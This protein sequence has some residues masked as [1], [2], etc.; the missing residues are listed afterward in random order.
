MK[1]KHAENLIER[2][3][4][5]SKTTKAVLDIGK[6]YSDFSDELEKEFPNE[7]EHLNSLKDK[8]P[9]DREDFLNPKGKSEVDISKYQLLGLT[10]ADE[11]LKAGIRANFI[12]STSHKRI[13]EI[14][15]LEEKELN[16]YDTEKLYEEAL[17]KGKADDAKI[18]KQREHKLII[19]LCFVIGGVVGIILSIIGI[20]SL[21]KKVET[22]V[23]WET[24]AIV[25]LVFLII[26]LNALVIVG[27]VF[28]SNRGKDN[29]LLSDYNE[30]V[31]EIHNSIINSY[32]VSY[33]EVLDNFSSYKEKFLEISKKALI[34]DNRIRGFEVA[35]IY[36]FLPEIDA[37]LRY[38]VLEMMLNVPNTPYDIAL[39]MV[40]RDVSREKQL[41]EDIAREERRYE[42]QK[43]LSKELVEYKE[44]EER[45]N[46]DLEYLARKEAEREYYEEKKKEN[47]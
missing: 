43:K 19:G 15:E 22:D 32:K 6:D 39:T 2:Y 31:E 42:A 13:K 28:L 25:G 9:K 12:S 37:D 4:K 18:K 26:A 14:K 8:L 30:R 40:N 7:V 20:A 46:R 23:Q 35:N 24:L 34:F 47:N 16:R 1:K 33:K 10:T 17:E 44:K 36:N 5:D 45:Y 41:S 38:R 21:S 27:I 3:V 29:Y 11:A